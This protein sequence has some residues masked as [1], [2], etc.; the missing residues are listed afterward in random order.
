MQTANMI[1]DKG[2]EALFVACDVSNPT[3]VTHLVDKTLSHFG[4]LNVAC[5]NAGIEGDV[6]PTVDSAI[7]NFDK[8]I[9]TRS[10]HFRKSIVKRIVIASRA[11]AKIFRFTGERKFHLFESI[12]NPLGCEKNKAMT[13]DQPGI[14]C[15]RVVNVPF[16]INSKRKT[17]PNVQGFT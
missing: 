4:Q 13:D 5:N 17:I 6:A 10:L 14:S 8:V 1:N 16:I 15:A 11:G 9:Q 2:G 7:D 12:E 3:D